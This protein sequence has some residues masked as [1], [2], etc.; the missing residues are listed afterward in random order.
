MSAT[1]TANEIDS[2]LIMEAARWILAE[3]LRIFVIKNRAEIADVI[4]GLAR[5]PE[6]LI[7]TYEDLPFLQSVSFTTEEEILA[8]P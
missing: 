4:R 7:R 3:I 2:R 1:Y 5:F 6:P 8:Q